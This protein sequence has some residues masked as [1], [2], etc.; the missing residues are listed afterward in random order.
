MKKILMIFAAVFLAFPLV[1][2]QYVKY[3]SIHNA[4][5]QIVG[6]QVQKLIDDNFIIVDV[7]ITDR[8]Y[9]I[10]YKDNLKEE[11]SSKWKSASNILF[12]E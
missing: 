8:G 9:L 10:V 12:G 7:E 3:E 11:A 1:A 5:V 6:E 2:K 4:S